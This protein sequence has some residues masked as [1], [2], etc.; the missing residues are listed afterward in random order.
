MSK[1]N[2]LSCQASEIEPD[3]IILT[4]TWC[5]E[6]ISNSILQIPGYSID[7]RLRRDRA[8]TNNGIGGG[9]IVYVKDGLTVLESDQ[10]FDFNQYVSFNVY[11]DD[12]GQIN[13]IAVYRSPNSTDENLLQLCN[14]IR[15]VNNN[16]IL[17]GDFNL[18]GINWNTYEADRKGKLFLEALD[19]VNATQLINVPTHVKGNI[20]D[21]VITTN[22]DKV[23]SADVLENLSKSDHNMILT[24]LLLKTDSSLPTKKVFE[25]KKADSAKMCEGLSGINWIES[26]AG[27]NVANMWSQLKSKLLQLQDEFVPQKVVKKKNRLPWLNR[28]LVKLIRKKKR[29]YKQHKQDPSA[30]RWENYKLCEKMVKKGVRNA[31]KNFEK[32]IAKTKGNGEKIFYSY[33]NAKTK[34]KSCIGPLKD[35]DGKLVTDNLGMSNILNNY[36]GSVYTC[37]DEST[38]PTSTQQQFHRE[39]GSI[40]ITPNIVVQKIEALKNGSAPGND[41]ISVELLKVTK[42][43][44][45][46]PLAYIFKE[47]IK[48]GEIPSDWKEANVTPIFKKGCKSVPANYRPIS[49]TSI[50]CKLMESIIKDFILEH[51]NVNN[52]IKPS[53]HGFT[54]NKNCTTNLLEFLQ[55]VESNIDGGYSVDVIYLDFA[56]AFDKVPKKRLISKLKAHGISGNLLAWIESWL[57]GRKQRVILN[58]ESSPWRDVLSGI[59]Q[60]S[61]LG[62]LLFVIFINDIDEVVNLDVFMKFADDTKGGKIIKSTADKDLFQSCIDKLFEWSIKWGMEFNIQKCKILHFGS[63][64]PNYEYF[65]NG[66]KLQKVDSEKDVGV[67]IHSS[68]KPSSQCKESARKASYVLNQLTKAFHFRDSK[69]FLQLYKRYVRPH[70]EYATPVWSPWTNEDKNTL[71]KVQIRAVHS[72]SGLHSKDYESK[73]KEL[74]IMSLEERRKRCDM[75]QVYKILHGIDNVDETTW[76][77][78]MSACSRNTRLAADPFNLKIRQFKSDLYKNFFS[79]RVIEHWNRLP[80]NIKCSKS[81]YQFKKLYD[82]LFL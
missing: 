6:S 26:F 10:P 52:L 45:S 20:L 76:F 4:E 63:K 29:L 32:H 17:V 43:F 1:L 35:E 80:S 41:S 51:L 33:I 39:L 36:F 12:G 28:D 67:V 31:K 57:T 13:I 22:Q 60:G 16:T 27:L 79:N 78:R 70:L 34:S 53:Q 44:V 49:L 8:D 77:K 46:V 18:P 68:L 59:I 25:W 37:E 2:E 47:S 73:L 66:V 42:Y 21:L 11:S 38:I 7:Q 56:K 54:K 82:R 19:S 62:P 15:S 48:T 64:N 30:E 3:L 24:E 50:C 55:A 5:N 14:L 40:Q 72:V 23:V 9:I 61:I 58:G 65:M 69:V 81:L 75:I 74:K 71:E